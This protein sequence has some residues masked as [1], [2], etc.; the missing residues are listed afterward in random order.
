MQPAHQK[1]RASTA[2]RGQTPRSAVLVLV[3]LFAGAAFAYSWLMP[4][5]EAP[6]EAAHY[7]LAANLAR[8]GKFSSIENNYEAHQPR[9]YYYIS[10]VALK[11]L[12]DRDRSWIA[13]YRPDPNYNNIRTELPVHPWSAENFR[14]VPG[15]YTLRWLNVLTAAA[16]V[17][18]NTATLFRILSGRPRLALAGAILAAFIPQ[19]LHI[20]SAVANDTLASLAGA[21]LFSVLVRIVEDPPGLPAAFAAGV[22]AALLPLATKL[23][24][25]GM[26]LAVLLAVAVGLW[27]RS[28]VP[29]WVV[30]AGGLGVAAVVLLIGLGLPE[31]GRMWLRVIPGRLT[32]VFEGAL[33]PATIVMMLAQ[34]ARTFWGQVGWIGAPLRDWIVI[35]L[36]GLAIAGFCRSAW[37]VLRERGEKQSAR[38]WAVIAASIALA[39]VLR[40]GFYT[41]ANQ[42]RLLFPALGPIA[43]AVVYGWSRLLPERFQ[44]RLPWLVGG[45][46]LFANLWLIFDK[47]L[48]IYF[49]P[50]LD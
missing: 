19:F 35:S 16:A 41:L 40:N 39:I 45:I 8:I 46:L 38:D 47:I 9:P 31:I 30:A 23:S 42:G 44:E 6:D 49:Q 22:A 1:T 3:F 12:Y 37:A 32:L 10:S 7:I 4:P 20:S 5:W 11:W 13:T 33:E 29:W 17:W 28:R 15:L 21:I 14:F 43:F 36:T 34:L 25:V 48:P 24:A 18:I 27:R 2:E 50:G 26:G